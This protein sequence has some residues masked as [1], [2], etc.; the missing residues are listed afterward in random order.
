MAET[1]K[2]ELELFA[3][4]SEVP[5][6]E[7]S[8]LSKSPVKII[9]VKFV[10]RKAH[11]AEVLPSSGAASFVC[12]YA[13]SNIGQGATSTFL[14]RDPIKKTV[15]RTHSR[16]RPCLKRDCNGRDIVCSWS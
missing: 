3:S 7:G 1:R 9:D 8:S 5:R 14:I 12:L 2:D 13:W 15:F 10:V 6:T 4:L 11:V 16:E